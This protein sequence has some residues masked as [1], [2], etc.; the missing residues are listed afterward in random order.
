MSNIDHTTDISAKRS[1]SPFALFSNRETPLRGASAWAGAGRARAGKGP[2]VHRRPEDVPETRICRLD[3]VDRVADRLRNGETSALRVPPKVGADSRLSE[4]FGDR[5]HLFTG[6][7]AR[8]GSLKRSASS[9]S[10]RRASRRARSVAVSDGLGVQV[11]VAV[12]HRVARGDA[13]GAQ[14]C[15][16]ALELVGRQA[17]VIEAALA[18]RRSAPPIDAIRG[19]S[20]F[21]YGRHPTPD[22]RPARPGGEQRVARSAPCK[23]VREH[24]LYHARVR[25]FGYSLAT[26]SRTA[27]MANQRAFPLHP[28]CGRLPPRSSARRSS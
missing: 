28:S 4:M 1:L 12:H 10:S 24:P 26:V 9:A 27:L 22:R 2:V 7:A 25:R 18:K 21:R 13:G 6:A 5:E 16:V 14:A 11:A 3:L 17:D 23:C 19:G 15:E 20:R 8:L